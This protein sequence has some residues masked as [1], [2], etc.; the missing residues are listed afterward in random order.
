MKIN[1]TELFSNMTDILAE[2]HQSRHPHESPLDPQDYSSLV[3]RYIYDISYA[4]LSTDYKAP[5][6]A[7]LKV[8]SAP[9]GSGKTTSA[10][11]FI[12]AL[13]RTEP[14]ATAVYCCETVN[15][16]ESLRLEL[17]EALDD[18]SQLKCW[19]SAHCA[20]ASESTVATYGLG[21]EVPRTQKS[22]MRK[23]P[24]LITTHAQWLQEA[25]TGVDN[26]VAMCNGWERDLIYIDENPTLLELIECTP[27]DILKLKEIVVNLSGYKDWKASVNSVFKRLDRIFGSDSGDT[28][29]ASSKPL[30][31]QRELDV[32]TLETLDEIYNRKNMPS[33]LKRSAARELIHFCQALALGHAFLSRSNQGH[34][35]IGY[36]LHFNP[37]HQMVLLD[38]TAS[39]SGLT[40]LLKA[41]SEVPLP[42]PLR[43]DNLDICHLEVPAKFARKKVVMSNYSKAVAYGDWIKA[44]VI[45]ETQ[46]GD[47]IFLVSHKDLMVRFQVFNKLERWEGR[48]VHTGHWGIGVGSNQ[49]RHCTHVF[50]M[51]S[52]HKPR[53]TVLAT[54]LGYQERKASKGNLKALNGG[55]WKGTPKEVGDNDLLRWLAQLAARGNCRNIDPAGQAGAMKL[56][57][58]MENTLLTANLNKLFPGASLKHCT[59]YAPESL[60]TPQ[61]KLIAMLCSQQ[62]PALVTPELF[63]QTTGI[64][65]G[66]MKRTIE[67]VAVAV[68]LQ[69]EGWQRRKIKVTPD[70]RA[71]FCLIRQDYWN[72]ADTNETTEA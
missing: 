50:L 25:E 47:E 69:H 57:T 3:H 20:N 2:I 18:P 27:S 56:Y 63:E 55:V 70:T 66:D 7:P 24:L 71:V 62:T 22:A 14:T 65:A 10:I 29:E 33:L 1:E 8:A 16:C 35:L 59:S 52:F 26:G 11:A 5:G 36:R 37:S 15:A 13:Q 68:H 19:T 48:T 61:A 42:P 12:A 45:A 17:T 9:T 4:A 67:R 38:A 34:T 49:Y 44:L 43:Y 72:K 31:T 39:V 58:T 32:L 21:D 40:K 28:F 23:S 51:G 30:M 6:N 60:S 54:A 53:R 46:P 64:K 41:G